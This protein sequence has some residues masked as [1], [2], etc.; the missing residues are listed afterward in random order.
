MSQIIDTNFSADNKRILKNTILL[1]FRMFFVMGISLYTSRVVLAVLGVEDFGIYNV[2]GGV[3]S[4]MIFFNGLLS[5]ASQRFITF[6]IGKNDIKYLKKI[7]SN[8]L[9]VHLIIAGIIVLILETI[10]IWALNFKLNIPDGRLFAANIVFQ[11]CLVSFVLS[12]WSIPYNAI[13]IAHEKMNAFAYISV[14]EATVKLGSVILLRLINYDKLILFAAFYM[15]ISVVIRLI[16][17]TYCIRKFEEGS[18]KLSIDLSVFKE[19]LS[20][21]GYNLL[22]V[23]ANMLADQGLNILL[24][25]FFGP[26]VNAARGIALQVSNAVNGFINNFSTAISPQIT[27]SYA[28]NELDRMRQ[29]MCLGNRL[30]FYLFLLIMLPLFF[31]IDYILQLWLETPPQYSANFIQ[32]LLISSLI[33]MLSR[34]FFVGI[35]ATGHIKQYQLALGLIRILILPLCWLFLM[36]RPESPLIVYYVIILFEIVGFFVKMWILHQQKLINS[37]YVFYT[38]FIPCL[39]VGILGFF[40]TNFLN[41]MYNDS[42]SG[43]LFLLVSEISVVMF[44]IYVIGINKHERFFIQKYIKKIILKN[45]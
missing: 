35:C 5:T 4:T 32:L 39:S 24:N 38:V 13:I 26:I 1:F 44:V 41:R 14:L 20:F 36:L 31:K 43:L 40:I 12:I 16:Y 19:I 10:G 18:S 22:E 27:K 45:N 34:T 29:L 30:C 3:V 21:S 6:A 15:G 25:L 28:S 11:C 37:N 2:V 7:V 9:S 8:C 33:M 17:S 42:I 23:F